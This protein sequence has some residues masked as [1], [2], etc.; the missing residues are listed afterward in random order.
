[1]DTCKIVVLISGTGSNLQAI[2][3]A[4]P[5]QQIPASLVAVISNRPDAKGLIKAAS[6]GIECT[7]LD[8][9]QFASREDFDQ[10]LIDCIDQYQPDL[11]VLAG[12]MRI[13][14]DDFIDHYA[15]RMLN[16]HPSL[17]P[18]FKGLNTHQRVLESGNQ[19]HGASVHFVNKEL[20]S[21]AIVIQA[22]INVR[23][24]D[25]AESLAGRVLKQEHVILPLAIKWFAQGRL[26]CI[27][28]IANFDNQVMTRPALW[29]DQ[30]LS[31]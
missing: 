5:Q 28:D 13:L 1:M 12:Y 10:A 17:L 20:D 15:G 8:H 25:D 4:I 21:G 19:T 22:M 31:Y 2:I 14:T 24:S 23:E 26:K 18:A 27:D 16:I 3:D 6:A 29:K 9:Q 11:I 30:Q 7:A